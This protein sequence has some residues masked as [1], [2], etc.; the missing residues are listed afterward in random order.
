M[1]YKKIEPNTFDPCLKQFEFKGEMDSEN[2]TFTGIANLTGI[3]DRGGDVIARG[4]FKPALSGFLKDGSILIGHEWDSLPIAMPLK[5]KDG[6]DGL[7]IECQ[8][9]SDEVAQRARTIL[10]ER[11]GSGKTVALS[12]GFIP[13][14][15]SCA[16]FES[17]K[18]MWKH[19]EENGLTDGLDKAG[20]MAW[21]NWCR[22]ISGVKEL[23]ETSI[24]TVGMNQGSRV[25]SVKTF[26]EEDPHGG[27]TFEDHATQTLGFVDAFVNRCQDYTN[28]K[29]E[30]NRPLSKAR[31]A[32][33]EALR[34]KLTELLAYTPAEVKDDLD[35]RVLALRL[36]A[37][38][39]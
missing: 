18:A 25:G 14:R 28:T 31:A 20:I 32:E 23:I 6:K 21:K 2:G 1:N 10:S 29:G 30:D 37:L 26:S 7:E 5:A 15:D 17:G 34:D 39:A 3:M 8:F 12:V 13:D 27:Q 9:H 24:V 4:A 16:W 35:D 19:C 11:I 36:Y 33:F 22:L 38:G